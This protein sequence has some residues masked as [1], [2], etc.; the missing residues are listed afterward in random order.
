MAAAAARVLLCAGLALALCALGLLAVAACSDHWYET[1]TRQHKERCRISLSRRNDPGYIYNYNSN[2]PLRQRPRGQRGG[3]FARHRRDFWGSATPDAA[4]FRHYNST[5][6]GLWT[7]CFRLGFDDEIDDLIAKGAVLRCVAVRYHF[8]SAALPRN[9][10][11]NVTLALR[12]DEWHSLHLRRMTVGFLGM[13][14]AV[15][16]FGWVVGALG[17]CRDRGLMQYV[18][19]LLFLMGGTFCII[20]L[21]TFV[22]EINFELSRF[23]KSVFSLPGDIA[24]GYGWSM[25]CAW[26][27]LGLALLA[28]FLCTLAPSLAGPRT[29]TPK[30]LSENGM[31]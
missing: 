10:A 22:A 16:A 29:A 14:V 11:H 25:F 21:C 12:Q 7:R 24:H 4:C 13:A 5:H 8:S 18:A 1:D 3:R 6:T 15:V 27:G 2:L 19:G 28:G 17:G 23:P 30:P 31:V 20:S 26:G 9:L